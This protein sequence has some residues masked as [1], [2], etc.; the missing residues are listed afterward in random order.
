MKPRKRDI[1]FKRNRLLK[2]SALI[3][4][5][6]GVILSIVLF[7]ITG[8]MALAVLIIILPPI[9]IVISLV[10]KDKLVTMG[11]VKRMEN[12]FPDFLQLMSS[13]LRAGITIDRSLLLSVREE[14][15]PLDK[16][17]QKSGREIATGKEIE[18]SLLEMANR[19]GSEKIKKNI[20]ILISGIRA[21]GNMATLL[22]ETS[23]NM[24]EKEFIEKRAASNVLMYVIFV[25]LAVSIGAPAL[26]SLS[27][28]LVE[29]LSDMLAGLP[30]LEKTSVGTPFTLTSVNISPEFIFYFSI[31]FVV[32]T[33]VLASL[34]LGLVSK[35]DEKEGMKYLLP[36]LIISLV[37]FFGVRFV[38]SDV[39]K[40][41]FGGG[42]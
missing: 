11:R 31:V 25:F 6:I 16:E 19:I 1:N 30:D 14:F 38:L 27:T 5:F 23:R 2:K 41:L 40:G 36:M 3:G 33:C 37:C 29:T 18:A 12:A 34:V 15:D 32:L 22:E 4:A 35:G 26:F 39:L 7:L 42:A 28:I 21:G 8:N 17:I 10:L 20:L 24:R 13:N 9:A